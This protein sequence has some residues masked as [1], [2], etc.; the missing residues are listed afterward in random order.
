MQLSDYSTQCR[1]TH[2]TQFIV[3]NGQSA[4]NITRA[5]HYDYIYMPNNKW[6][7]I[8]KKW[9]FS[10]KQ[11]LCVHVS[12]CLCLP[13]ALYISNSSGVSA[14]VPCCTSRFHFLYVSYFIFGFNAIKSEKAYWIENVNIA[15]VP[16][17]Q[18][19][20]DICWKDGKHT[21]IHARTRTGERMYCAVMYWLHM[22]GSYSLLPFRR[23]KNN[24]NSSTIYIALYYVLRNKNRKFDAK[25]D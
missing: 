20:Y 5:P 3:N 9:I 21:T 17:V 12:V 15:C 16:H 1:N 8:I 24:N 2:T 18:K 13:C 14:N 19:Y 10:A 11:T 7:Y 22:R 6:I 4:Y 23:R 25:Y